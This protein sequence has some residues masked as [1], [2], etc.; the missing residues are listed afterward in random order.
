MST[1]YV[2][3]P[4]SLM[5]QRFADFL[6]SLMPGLDW[7]DTDLADAIE[8]LLTAHPDVYVVWRED[9]PPQVDTGAA[10]AAGYGAAPGDEVIEVRARP[11]AL[12]SLCWEMPAAA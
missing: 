1:F 2:L 4:R 11:G 7:S 3:P 10:L 5:G 8:S 6:T 12:A 9:L